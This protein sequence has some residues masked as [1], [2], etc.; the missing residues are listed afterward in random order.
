MKLAVLSVHDRHPE[1][2]RDQIERLARCAGPVRAALNAELRL[3]PIVHSLTREA[4]LDAVREGCA[5]SGGFAGCLDLRDC[6]PPQ[7]GGPIHGHSLAEAYRQLRGAG[8]LED[9]D[10]LAVLDHDAHP[11]RTD[12]FAILSERLLADGSLAGLGIP[13]WYHGRCY[14]HPALLLTRVAMVEEMGPDV[15]LLPR[16]RT[17]DPGWYDTC[18]GFTVWCEQR[19][20]PIL[21]L[22]VISTGYPLERW[23][24]DMAPGGGTEL[25]GAHGERVRVGHLMRFG[26]EPDLPLASHIWAGF[27]GPYQWAGFSPWSWDEI[28]AAYLAE[29]LA[30]P[31]AG[32]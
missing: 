32:P 27:L 6:V 29:P 22:R 23:D 28:L 16:D 15:A 4:V 10:L 31:L 5:E 11:L 19:S 18:E 9:G 17:A 2:W 7:E 12:S 21:P 24:S 3:W 20:R 8:E 13:Q 1:L 30:E 14:L 26:L 25:T